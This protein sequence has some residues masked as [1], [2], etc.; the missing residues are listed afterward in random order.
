VKLS[1][2]TIQDPGH[3][4]RGSGLGVLG[5]TYGGAVGEAVGDGVGGG[6]LGLGAPALELSQH[7]EPLAH[8]VGV[9]TSTEGLSQKAAIMLSRQNPG[10][11]GT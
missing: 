9:E 2:L 5:R 1:R 8:V 7:T 10:Q 4:S 6:N 3:S 11:R